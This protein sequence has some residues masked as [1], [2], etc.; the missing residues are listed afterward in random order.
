M[1]S[2]RGEAVT[3]SADGQETPKRT[4]NEDCC[5]KIATVPLLLAP[6]AL[7]GNLA[8]TVRRVQ[9]GCLNVLLRRLQ[10]RFRLFRRTFLLGLIPV[11][12][13][14]APCVSC[15]GVVDICERS[16]CCVIV[17][18]GTA[19]GLTESLGRSRRKD[20]QLRWRRMSALERSEAC[21]KRAILEARL[22][23]TRNW[24]V[25][26]GLI[27]ALLFLFLKFLIVDVLWHVKRADEV[28]Q[29]LRNLME[30]VVHGS[31]AVSAEHEFL[32]RERRAAQRGREFVAAFVVLATVVVL[33]LFKDG[34]SLY[35]L[36]IGG[37][38]TR[39]MMRANQAIAQ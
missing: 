18:C 10:L 11:A 32:F 35:D 4:R 33:A 12:L 39:E 8:S 13:A 14:P 28:A 3:V 15:A 19:Y 2:K 36:L 25:L 31:F 34:A 6:V 24:F 1:R 29:G 38:P 16:R 9:S 17:G 7:L 27:V 30:D 37:G 22:L 21:R 23:T 5:E 20:A 26:P